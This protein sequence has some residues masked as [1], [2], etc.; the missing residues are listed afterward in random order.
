VAQRQV[1]GYVGMTGLATGPHLDYRVAKNGVW[2]NP[3]SEK[4]L[5]GEPISMAER[6]EFLTH[7]RTLVTRLE[8]E[9]SF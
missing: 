5:P 2:V 9:A 4:F 8:R 7:A 3:L 6:S 1:V